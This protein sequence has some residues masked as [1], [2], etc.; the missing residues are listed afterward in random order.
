MSRKGVYRFKFKEKVPEILIEACFSKA[1]YYT[2]CSFGKQTVKWDV[3]FYFGDELRLCLIDVTSSAGLY[4][5]QLFTNYLREDL[6]DVLFLVEQIVWDEQLG[7][8]CR[9]YKSS[10]LGRDSDV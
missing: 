3:W 2:E 9:V 6:Q 10:K 8:N 5:A 1:L 7:K 4:L